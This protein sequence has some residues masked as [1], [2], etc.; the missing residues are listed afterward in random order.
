[1]DAAAR[2]V[3]RRLG[4]EDP[5]HVEIESKRRGRAEQAEELRV[6]QEELQQSNEELEERAQMLEQQREAIR[7][8]NKEI[9]ATSD[10]IRL[11]SRDAPEPGQ[12]VAA[13]Q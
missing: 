6:Q 3:C 10:E 9:E 12:G 8:K 1:M 13:G 7:V 2:E 11:E 5:R 4:I